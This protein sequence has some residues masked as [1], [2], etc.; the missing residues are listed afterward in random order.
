MTTITPIPY[1]HHIGLRRSAAAGAATLGVLFILC[2]LGTFVDVPVTHAWIS[3][4]TPAPVD[5]MQALWE[6]LGWS[7][8]LGLV[9]GG[10]GA[11]FFNS[12]RRLERR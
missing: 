10:V 8:V 5:S 2:W 7:L 6:G 11:F 9:A 1:E 12:F 4:F 3:L